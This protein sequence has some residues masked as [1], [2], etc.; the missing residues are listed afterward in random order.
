MPNDMKTIPELEKEIEEQGQFIQ[1]IGEALNKTAS[2][3]NDLRAQLGVHSPPAAA[4][5]L[6]G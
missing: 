5:P 3:L 6:A 1:A 4:A 2:D